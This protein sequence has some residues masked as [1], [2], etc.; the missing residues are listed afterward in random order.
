M[1]GSNLVVPV[2][3]W[4][5]NALTHCISTIHLSEDNKNV[6][7]GCYDGQIC[8]WKI[9]PD[10]DLNLTPQYLLIGH[11]API[12]AICK[13]SILPEYKYIV[14]ASECGEMC[15]WDLADGKCIE[16]VKLPQVHTSLQ[17]YHMSGSE[18]VRLFCN[19]YYA[20]ILIMDP[21]SLEILFSLNSKVNPDWISALHVSHSSRF[22]IFKW[23]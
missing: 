8:I 4:G 19:G 20:E 23:H 6:V 15:L 13:A 9:D 16:S 22:F 1:F 21:F 7:T 3:L 12:L 14:S 5:P 11:T 17:A 18:D 10:N 2:V